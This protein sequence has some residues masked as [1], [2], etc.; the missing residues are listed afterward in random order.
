[1][2]G[3]VGFFSKNLAGKSLLCNMIDSLKHQGVYCVDTY[4]DEHFACARVHRGIFNPEPQPLFNED[5]SLC[6]FFDGKIYGYEEQLEK[7]KKKG[8]IFRYNNDVEFCLHSFD[9]YGIDFIKELNGSFIFVIYNLMNKNILIAND[10]LGYLVHYYSLHNG[11]LLFGSEIKA[12][13]QE[14]TF[15]KELNDEA[16]AEYFAYREFWGDKTFF[17]RINLLTAASI[18]TYNG[19]KLSHDNYWKF[20]YQSDYKKSKKEFV[21]ELVDT[22]RVAVKRRMEDPLRY[23]ITLS[24]GLDSRT[25]LAGMN[26]EKR[27]KIITYTFGSQDCDEVRIAQQ[28]ARKAGAKSKILEIPPE[29]IIK[30]AKNEIVLTEGRSYIGVSFGYPA[31]QTVKDEIDV[32]FDGSALDLTLGGS[33]LRMERAYDLLHCKNEDGLQEVILM[34][35]T[36]F[37]PTEFRYLFNKK[38]YEL[39]KDV[40]DRSFHIEFNKIYN[41]TSFANMADQFFINT[42]VAYM[43]IG[44]VPVRDLIEL[45]H[46]T[47]DND[48]IDIVRKIPPKWRKNHNIYRIFLKKLS[49][50]LAK[51]PYNSTM[52]RADAPLFFWQCG[53]YYLNIREMIKRK[54]MVISKG[55]LSLPNKRKYADID[56]WFQTNKQWQNFFREL[57]LNQD[58]KSKRYINQDYVNQLFEEQIKGKKSNALKLMYLASFEIFLQNFFNE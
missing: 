34:K 54:L 49:P 30:Y 31:L 10:R 6:I 4:F 55:S 2:V 33:Y 7:L 19:K 41:K 22:Y 24:G 27:K 18:L 28:V 25:V 39:I 45:S 5:K 57:L 14:K 8:Y 51:I 44:D 47:T 21:D 17:K 29:Y 46:P 26:P 37:N 52:I 15:K 35:M 36:M 1:M 53:K 40:P 23:G 13:L 16:V 38:Y 3:V 56:Q 20:T 58:N 32:I 43:H 9:E 50:E 42:H 48:F 11:N 12:I